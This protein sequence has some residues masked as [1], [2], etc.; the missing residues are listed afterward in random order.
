VGPVDDKSVRPAILVVITRRFRGGG[1]GK[2]GRRHGA[3]RWKG[4]RRH[5][6]SMLNRTV[7]AV[8]ASLLGCQPAKAFRVGTSEN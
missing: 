2:G 3:G 8:I 7:G 1:V 4:R 5:D 6:G